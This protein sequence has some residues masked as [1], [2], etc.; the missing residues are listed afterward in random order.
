[1]FFMENSLSWKNPALAGRPEKQ[2]QKAKESN[3][4]GIT[5]Q[6]YK[7]NACAWEFI[8]WTLKPS[9][10]LQGMWRNRG[11]RSQGRP[12]SFG[13][14]PVVEAPRI[15]SFGRIIVKPAVTL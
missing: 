9:F 8:Q 7:H 2:D 15:A 13:K 11:S 3:Y 6:N 10:P 5:P 1:M 12:S 14:T 4:Q